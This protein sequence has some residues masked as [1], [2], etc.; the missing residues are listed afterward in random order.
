MIWEHEHF[1]F[2]AVLDPVPPRS[3]SGHR[4]HVHLSPGYP[5]RGGGQER[6]RRGSRFHPL[7]DFVASP[8]TTW[9]QV[10][11]PGSRH[12]PDSARGW[13]E[14]RSIRLLLSEGVADIEDKSVSQQRV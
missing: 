6:T 9:E 5:G 12:S 1:Q 14:E 13:K 4:A 11:L 3:P 8:K 7:P 2:C 10:A